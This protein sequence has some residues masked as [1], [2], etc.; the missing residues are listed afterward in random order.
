MKLISER[1]NAVESF[2][3][4][5]DLALIGSTSSR[6]GIYSISIMNEIRIQGNFSSLIV[7]RIKD[8]Y[9]DATNEI[10]QSGFVEFT[11]EA[12]DSVFNVV[13]T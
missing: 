5:L 10:T 2:C 12:F 9:P 8:T 11:I 7:N 4:S 3:N 1:L 13:L 6:G